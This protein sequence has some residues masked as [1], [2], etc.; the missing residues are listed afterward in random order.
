MSSL[1]VSSQKSG[2]NRGT[3]YM[4]LVE[5]SH[6]F[7]HSLDAPSH[8]IDQECCRLRRDG[9]GGGAFTGSSCHSADRPEMHA[10]R[11]LG[12]LNMQV[13][14]HKFLNQITHYTLTLH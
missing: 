13:P 14:N 9:V 10:H 4:R 6:T 7:R 5:L 3:F 8:R 1:I 11:L 12:G 2:E